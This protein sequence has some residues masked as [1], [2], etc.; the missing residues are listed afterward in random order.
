VPHF[1]RKSRRRQKWYVA[2][3]NNVLMICRV[4]T[5]TIVWLCVC[6]CVCVGMLFYFSKDRRF[7]LKTLTRSELAFFRCVSAFALSVR[8]PSP[9][10][11]MCHVCG[12][13]KILKDYYQHLCDNPHTLLSRFYGYLLSLLLSLSSALTCIACGRH[14]ICKIKLPGAKAQR[15]IIMNNLFKTTLAIH[16]KFDLKGSVHNR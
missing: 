8:Y 5:I 3:K 15:L 11:L 2:L 10:N 13:S 6:V 9:S 4:Q 7:V 14:S 1:G 12:C 16:E